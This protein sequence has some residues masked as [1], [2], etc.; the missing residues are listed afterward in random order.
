MDEILEDE[1]CEEMEI[2][3][4]E[5]EDFEEGEDT[6]VLESESGDFLGGMMD[7]TVGAESDEVGE[8]WMQDDFASV[9]NSTDFEVGES[10][11]SINDSVSSINT[12]D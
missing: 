3:E 12:L 11:A 6:E 1:D 7:G 9:R 4:A 5:R 8:D 2:D 10:E